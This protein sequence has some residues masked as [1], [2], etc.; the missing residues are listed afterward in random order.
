MK[1]GGLLW[2]PFF[3]LDLS[4]IQLFNVLGLTNTGKYIG[5]CEAVLMPLL[6]YRMRCFVLASISLRAF[7]MAASSFFS[8]GSAT[9]YSRAITLFGSP[10]SV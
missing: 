3:I 10:S 1:K 8:F 6:R 2:P 9:R 7:S 5:C 4:L